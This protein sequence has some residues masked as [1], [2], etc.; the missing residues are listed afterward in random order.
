MQQSARS[1]AQSVPFSMWSSLGNEEL[2]PVA[3]LQP[4]PNKRGTVEIFWTCTITLVL[5]VW[6]AVH[7]NIPSAKEIEKKSASKTLKI[8]P[9]AKQMTYLLIALFMPELV[10]SKD[11]S[12]VRPNGPFWVL[13]LFGRIFVSVWCR[14]CCK[15]YVRYGL[16][17]LAYLR[18]S[19]RLRRRQCLV[20]CKVGCV[21]D[22]FAHSGKLEGGRSQKEES[23]VF[24]RPMRLRTHLG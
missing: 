7:L 6:T 22:H 5:C 13:H 14:S 18:G 24:A 4:P 2:S 23:L 16:G 21:M 9:T 11:G 20:R 12:A 8:L 3:R 10:S 1:V 17:Q 15:D 19:S